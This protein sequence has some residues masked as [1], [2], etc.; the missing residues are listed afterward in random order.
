MEGRQQV[1][2]ET[3]GALPEYK[4]DGNHC[5]SEQQ[6]K[7]SWGFE[8]FANVS[9]R[10]KVYQHSTLFSRFDSKVVLK[11][12]AKGRRLWIGVWLLVG[13]VWL[14]TGNN[15]LLWSVHYLLLMFSCRC[16]Y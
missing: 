15:H 4:Q 7:Q 5:K 16:Y 12:A 3:T 11:E 13:N 10:H 14:W 9:Q 2:V 6:D 1:G 8:G